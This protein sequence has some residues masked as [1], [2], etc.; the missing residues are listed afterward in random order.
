MKDAGITGGIDQVFVAQHGAAAATSQTAV[1]SA[2]VSRIFLEPAMAETVEN[3]PASSG[4]SAV[5]CAYTAIASGY[6]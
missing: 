1:A 5:K 3:G 2:L 4:A 6:G